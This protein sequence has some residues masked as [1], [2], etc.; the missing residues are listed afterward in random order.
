M[1]TMPN[2]MP[3]RRMFRRMSPL[4]TW[5]NS[6]AITPCSSSRVSFSRQPRVTAIAA[7]LEREAGGERVD[8][9]FV[10]E[11][12]HLRHRHARRDRHFFDH[13]EQALLERVARA[14]A[15]Q[16]PAEHL[17]DLR[18]AAAQRQHA[19]AARQR[20]DHARAEQRSEQQLRLEAAAYAISSPS[21]D[22]RS[23]VL[24]STTTSSA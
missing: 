21:A 4:S 1:H 6:C 22:R 18:A 15:D 13:V 5:L 10:L 24:L 23:P 9:V 11:H 2:T 20:H 17:R 16:A 7:S 14:A 8:A 3:I 19:H 12:E